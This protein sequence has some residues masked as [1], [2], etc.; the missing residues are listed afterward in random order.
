MNESDPAWQFF[1]ALQGEADPHSINRS[2]AREE[3]LDAVLDDIVRDPMTDRSLLLKRYYSRCRN[4][5]SKYNNRRAL[6]RHRVRGTHRRGGTEFGSVLLT[7][8]ERNAFDQ[9][10]CDQFT[11]MVRAVLPE[12]EFRLLLEIGDGDSYAD[13]ANDR[14]VSLSTLKSKVFRVRKKV[15]NSGIFATLRCGLR[16]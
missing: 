10:A 7:R 2:L 11:N 5:L 9:I 12:G 6:D 15:R 16:H 4:R 13:L 14:N 3:A 1:A 8:P